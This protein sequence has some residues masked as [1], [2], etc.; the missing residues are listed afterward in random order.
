VL[1]GF[2]QERPGVEVALRE[3]TTVQQLDALRDRHIDVGFVRTPARSQGMAQKLLIEEQFVAALPGTHA[4]AAR[5]GLTLRELSAERF[6]LYPRAVAAGL[7]DRIV[8]ACQRAGFSP[9]VV[10]ETTQT[11][12]MVGLV[13]AGLGVA[14]VPAGVRMLR[15]ENVAYVPLTGPRPT[16]NIVLVWRKD[17]EEPAVHAFVRHAERVAM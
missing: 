8:S 2:R 5:S 15:W 16:T 7:Y 9:N 13:A 10:Q 4:L 1:R 6:I 11:P 14:L 12:V 3:L 17:S